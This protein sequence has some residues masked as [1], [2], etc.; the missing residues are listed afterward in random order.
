MIKKCVSP[1][2]LHVGM[3]EK[4]ICIHLSETY[5][6]QQMRWWCVGWVGVGVYVCMI[7]KC[8]VKRPSRG[9]HFMPA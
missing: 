3:I 4:G 2:A 9:Q 6:K 1:E 7:E 5:T 8:Q